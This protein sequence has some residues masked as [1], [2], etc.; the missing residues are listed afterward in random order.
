MASVAIIGA[1]C[2]GTLVSQAL[3]SRSAQRP[4]SEVLLFDKT[5]TFGPGLPYG[6]D[7]NDEGFLLNMKSSL[8]GVDPRKDGDFA[9]WLKNSPSQVAGLLQEYAPRILMGQ[10]L[11]EVVSDTAQKFNHS[12]IRFARINASVRDVRRTSA[13]FEVHT[14]N[15]VRFVDYIVLAVGHL[16]K[17]TA[18]PGVERHFSNPYHDLARIKE[19]PAGS[20]VGVLGSKLT[21]VDMALLLRR[22]GVA[23]V[24]MFSNSGQLPLVR[25]L[26]P[27]DH[28]GVAFEECPGAS[29]L[30][31]FRWFRREKTYTPEYVGFITMREVLD[32]L[33]LEIE[34]A[35]HVRD[36]QLWLDGTKGWIDEYWFRMS[37]KE[38]RRFYRKYQGLWM[39]YRHPMPLANAL[40]I[41]DMLRVGELS[42]HA[43]YKSTRLKADEH[44]EVEVSDSL[45]EL[46]Y[47]I[48]ATGVSGNLAKLDSVL[49]ENMID[50]GILSQYEFG[51][52]AIDPE[53][54]Q[55]FEQ[56]GAYAIGPLTQGSLF[57]VSAMERLVI[58]AERV[59]E[60]IVKSQRPIGSIHEP[61]YVGVRS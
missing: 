2:S 43:G 33:E 36:W 16:R 4:V 15:D 8:L 59:V 44:F 53:T 52:V 21:A 13:G 47:V 11:Q 7:T 26:I 46:D 37:P 30:D 42:V 12:G 3:A 48:D 45:L 61:L 34:A 58:H 24:H 49:I 54:H 19:I 28:E 38:K 60:H 1:G 50:S 20:R 35:A 10:Y 55:L 57:Y 32:R 5:S 25:G 39:S 27:A 41:R 23:H 51:G 14:A 56:P 22:I 18:F 9:H 31:F 6:Q 17:R 29:I 40:K